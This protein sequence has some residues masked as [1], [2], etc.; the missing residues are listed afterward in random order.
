M[1][2][3]TELQNEQAAEM[4]AEI[5]EPAATIFADTDVRDALKESKMSGVKTAM[6]KHSKELIDL[7]AIIDG[8]DRETYSVNAIQIVSKTLAILSDKELVQAFTL[9]AQTAES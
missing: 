2:R 3:L 4:L 7:L 1:S 9:Q 5:I 8:A 6:K